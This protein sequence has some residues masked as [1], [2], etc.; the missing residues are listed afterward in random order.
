MWLRLKPVAI[1]CSSVA[2]GQQVA[3]DLL[4]GELVEREVA[5]EAPSIDLVA[6]GPH[7][8]RAVALVAVGVGVAGRVEPVARH[9]L[10]VARRRQQPVD[11]LLVGVR[12]SSSRKAS[13]S[14]GVGGRP[15]RSKDTRR[16]SHARPAPPATAAA[17][18]FQPGEHEEK[19]TPLRGQLR[20]D[21]RRL[22]AAPAPLGP[23]LVP[24]G[25][26]LDP[27]DR[28]ADLLPPSSGRSALRRSAS[29]SA[30]P[31]VMRRTSS[32]SSLL[33][34][35]HVARTAVAHA[36]GVVFRARR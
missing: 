7:G 19:S 17:F 31:V 33:G 3:G 21:R 2:F 15:V 4:D 35:S 26:L 22:G 32:L 6:P 16:T 13:T 10:A 34:T 29:A 24:G 27:A 1:F 9:A 36:Q 5:V 14:A 28:A 18:A 25:A 30:S 12:D 20:P 23:V 8:P 11:H